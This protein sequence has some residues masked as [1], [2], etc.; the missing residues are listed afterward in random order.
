[1]IETL[2]LGLVQ[3]IAEFLPI[4]SDGH[5]AL[6]S[7]LFHV[8]DAGLTLNVLLHVGTLIATAV[9]LRERLGKAISAGFRALL[10][11]SLFSSDAGG[12][13]A[14]FV[15]MASI[16][17]AIIGLLLRDDVE[18]WTSSPFVV[19]LGFLATGALLVSTRFFPPG[20]VEHPSVR[21][22]LLM[23]IAQG[24]AVLP[25]V[26]RSGTTIA[27]ALFLGVQRGR[28]FEL[29]MLMSVPAVLGAALLELPR[30][31]GSFD[32]WGPGILGAVVA[33]I[34][35]IFA[36]LF[37]RR[38]VVSGSFPWFALWVIPLGIAT[39]MMSQAWPH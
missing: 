21:V 11:P 25:G 26:S 15:V 39:L 5:L 24:A 22:A 7:M 12:Q 32:S 38:M 1:V 29:S 4:S 9:V 16:P 17:T 18:R 3:G 20:A 30:A 28:A 37:L 31:A 23:G 35:G 34:S 27:L 14:L 36:M 13:D 6:A 10:K 33:C 8:K 19:G 2:L